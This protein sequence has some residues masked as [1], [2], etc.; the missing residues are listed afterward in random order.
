MALVSSAI[1][2]TAGVA[3]L[4]GLG[5]AGAIAGAKAMG[6][7]RPEVPKVEELPEAPTEQNAED[8]AKEEVKRK[9][10]IIGRTG[11]KTI[12]ESRYGGTVDAQKKTFLGQ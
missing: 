10:K 2:G 3:A 4:L 12:L 11:G 1:A 7:G 8:K 5:T 9:K 6:G